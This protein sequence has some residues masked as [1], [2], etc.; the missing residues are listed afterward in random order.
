MKR[1]TIFSLAVF[2]LSCNFLHAQSLSATDIIRKADEKFNGEE[3]GISTMVMTI[4]RPAWQRTVEF[5]S[6][7]KGREN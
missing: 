7:S 3:S 2:G 5:R 6:W 4:V 1:N